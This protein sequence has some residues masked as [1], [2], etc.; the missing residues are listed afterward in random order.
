MQATG[1]G[2]GSDEVLAAKRQ[3][4]MLECDLTQ[5]EGAGPAWR[6]VKKEVHE[7]E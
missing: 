4:K 3:N 5:E 7:V 2:G 1:G 6:A